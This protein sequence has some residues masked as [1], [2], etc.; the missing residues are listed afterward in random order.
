VEHQKN[1]TKEDEKLILDG[2]IK[3]KEETIAKKE[4]EKAAKLKSGLSLQ[5][6]HLKQIVNIS[7]TLENQR[8]AQ[9][10]G[11]TRHVG[12]RTKECKRSVR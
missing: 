3:M 9:G 1:K 5:S 12:T 4:A 11:E 6:Y 8:G 2:Y 10:K 7:L